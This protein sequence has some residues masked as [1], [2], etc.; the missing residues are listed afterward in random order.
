MVGVSCLQSLGEALQ[1][2]FVYLVSLKNSDSGEYICEGCRCPSRA[3]WKNEG[4]R[5]DAVRSIN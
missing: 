4:E 2:V 5:V 1:C 3:R